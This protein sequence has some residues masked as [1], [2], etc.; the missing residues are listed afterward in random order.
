[1]SDR[2]N[3]WTFVC[4]PG[5]SLPENYIQIID[6]WHVPTLLSPVHNKDKN[7]D[8]SEKKKHIHVMLYFGSG[9][10]KSFNQVKK[11][12]DQLGATRPEIVRSTNSLIRYFIHRDNPEKA[13][14]RVEDLRAYGGFEYLT[15][16]E[17]YTNDEQCYKFIEDIINSEVIYNLHTL[18]VEL[19]RRNCNYEAMFVR[20]HTIYFRSYL[21]GVYQKIKYK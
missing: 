21:D 12:S 6:N 3:V 18:V 13:Q 4:Y 11:L 16:F 19:R 10:N 17:N 8:E 2:S 1:M 14:Y 9:A 5:D 20:K 7:G 15:A